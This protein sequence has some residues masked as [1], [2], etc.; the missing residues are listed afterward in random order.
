MDLTDAADR[1]AGQYSLGMKQRLG[2]AIALVGGPRL[3]LLDEWIKLKGEVCCLRLSRLPTGCWKFKRR[4][5][6]TPR[7]L[8]ACQSPVTLLIGRFC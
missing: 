4:E 6:R 2:I 1:R 5:R 7:S 3:L 8:G